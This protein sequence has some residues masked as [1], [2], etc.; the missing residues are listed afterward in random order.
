MTQTTQTLPAWRAANATPLGVRLDDGG[1]SVAVFAQAQ[2]V[3]VRFV[4]P[5]SRRV[6]ARTL[7]PVEGEAGVW[8][9]RIDESL[10]GWSYAFDLDRDGE[11]LADI[12]D[13]WARLI[14]DGRGYVSADET[15]VSPRPRIEPR[16][17]IIYELHVRDFTRDPAAGVR[18]GWQGKYL[19]LAQEGTRLG[20]ADI[21]TGL[22]HILDLGVNT[23]QLMPVHAFAMPYD[24]EYEWGYMPLYFNAPHAGYASG[25]ELEAPV[26]EFKRLVSALHERGLRVTLDV[27]Y[28]HTAE[29]WPDR[30]RSL[31][32]LAP[33]EYFRFQDTG[34]PHNGSACGNEFRSESPMG[35]RFL[36]ESTLYWVEH[37]GVDGFRFDLMGLIDAD[38]MAIIA[39]EIHA[40]DPTIL[41]YGEPWAGGLAGI[42]I[43]D[44]GTQRSRG[45]SVFNDQIRD[46][47]RGQTFD[48]ED[49]GFLNA[50]TDVP[51]VKAGI[52]GGIHSFADS[53]L[54]SINYIECHD[55]H[56]LEDRLR[57][58]HEKARRMNVSAADHDRM[59][60][61]GVLALM[62]SQ[63]IPFLH[64][65]QEFGRTKGGNDNTYNM[66]DAINN[67]RWQDKAANFRRYHFHRDAI[68]MR[69][70]HPMFRLATRE[71][72]ERA[73]KFL[74]D[75]LGLHLPEGTI[76]YQVTDV[77]GEDR[78]A[79]AL[80]LLNGSDRKC[81]VPLPPPPDDAEA[82]WT[83]CATCGSFDGRL[84]GGKVRSRGTHRL[85]AHSGAVL[86]RLAT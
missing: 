46:G 71:D 52:L 55:N 14:R 83:V 82:S 75:D 65:G 62:T 78:W 37:F 86:F 84:T 39:A 5:D 47:L 19:G 13:P 24:P 31:M 3:R 2:G 16:D 76:G 28:N 60:R 77:T 4:H 50:G 17:A 26:R 61:L 49:F 29:R 15:A 42:D 1:T 54:E 43:N 74:D 21:S 10:A 57:L 59:S 7:E 12:V 9:V 38:T 80:V 36:V 23:V 48:V 41:V 81:E 20:G 67:I 32:A 79:H 72:V 56:T 6:I 69:K 44:K 45:W 58:T 33:H 70:T 18:P 25:V 66:G 68:A 34:E 51:D 8:S 85:D 40:I 22:D 53:P 30:L 73:V 64:A 63:G 27:V 35:R 11:T